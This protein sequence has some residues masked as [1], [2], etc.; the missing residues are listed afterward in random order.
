MELTNLTSGAPA[1]R[2]IA[3]PRPEIALRVHRNISVYAIT[4]KYVSRYIAR[5]LKFVLRQSEAKRFSLT[6]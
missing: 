6:S 3:Y 5:Q 4:S 1:I 2:M